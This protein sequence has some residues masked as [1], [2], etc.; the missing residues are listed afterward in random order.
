MKLV[1]AYTCPEAD[2]VLY[3]L[4]KERPIENRISHEKMPTH[5]EHRAFIAGRPFR[6]WFLIE[7][8]EVSERHAKNVFVGAIE[9][10]DHNEIGVSILSEYQRKGYGR[11]A[12]VLFM[13]AHHPLP[14]IPAR[15]NGHW[16]ANIAIKNEGSKAFFEQ[17]GFAPIQ[18]TWVKR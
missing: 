6:F 2:A 16:L 15:R 18:E 10:T 5:A 12:L 1:D 7:S 3:Q 13:G 4:L 8:L 9:V 17:C 14:A 11:Q